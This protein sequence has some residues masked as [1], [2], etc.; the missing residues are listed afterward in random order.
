MISR[1]QKKQPGRSVKDQPLDQVTKIK[2]GTMLTCKYKADII[3]VH[4]L[5]SL[6]HEKF[7]KEKNKE[8]YACVIGKLIEKREIVY[9]YVRYIPGRSR[10][11]KQSRRK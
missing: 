8:K 1:R 9:I 10:F 7:S 5:S 3:N 2:A 6:S 4:C 11:C